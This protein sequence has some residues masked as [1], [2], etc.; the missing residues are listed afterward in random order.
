M[1]SE[2]HD[3]AIDLVRRVNRFQRAGDLDDAT[4][5]ELTVAQIR[6]LFRLRNRGPMPSSALASG[7]GVTLP[8]VTSV[9]DRLVAKEL[10]ERTD[11]AADRR[12]VIVGLTPAGRE[13]VE[14][15]QQ[16]RRARLSRA[17]D[18]LDER[19]LVALIAGLEALAAAADS[20]DATEADTVAS[21]SA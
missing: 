17:I 18:A 21:Q 1:G 16:G 11:D 10:V 4:V 12:R 15:I 20:L 6:V 3:R 7:L 19:E 8:T 5:G 9:I 14:R 2:S 13:I